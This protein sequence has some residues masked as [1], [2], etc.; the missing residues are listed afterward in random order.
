MSRKSQVE[1]S[2]EEVSRAGLEGWVVSADDPVNF[3]LRVGVVH[4]GGVSTREYRVLRKNKLP[5]RETT[6]FEF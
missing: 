6:L 3:S 1:S 2:A 4:V 5:P